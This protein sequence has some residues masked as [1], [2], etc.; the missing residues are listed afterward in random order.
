[1][2]TRFLLL[3]LAL[4]SV[5][6]GSG[7]AGVELEDA[8]VTEPAGPNAALYFTATSDNGDRLLSA[9]T[10]EAASVQL[11]ETRMDSDGT[12]AMVPVDVMEIPAGGELKLEPGGLHLMLLDA[13]SFTEG[14]EIEVTLV[15]ENAGEQTYS[16]EVVAPG[17]TMGHDH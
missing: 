13:E 5:A 1:M 11:H 15:W 3:V 6:C 16:I 7:S 10:A 4:V 14:S 9:S 17:D 8:R 2:K 12:M